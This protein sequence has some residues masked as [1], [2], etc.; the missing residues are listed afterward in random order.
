MSKRKDSGA[1]PLPGRPVRGSESGRPVMA[2]LDLLGRRWTLR[3]LWELHQRPDGFRGLQARCDG[4]SSSVL[5]TRLN[6]LTSARLVE[7]GY[8]LT[9][10]GEE[11]VEAMGPMVEWSRRWADELT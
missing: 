8:R 4:M 5:A 3:I 9:G 7:G 6:E 10:L 1:D 2:A 11:L